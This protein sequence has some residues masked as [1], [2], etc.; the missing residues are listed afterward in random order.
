MLAFCFCQLFCQYTGMP[1]IVRI[2]T[3][4]VRERKWCTCANCQVLP[5]TDRCFFFYFLLLHPLNNC[6]L[7]P[8]TISL[9]GVPPEAENFPAKSRKDT[10]RIIS[11][12]T[13]YMF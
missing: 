5:L 9:T 3:S 11:R 13:K 7:L 12:T 1:S 4:G 8:N 10:D 6:C 2:I